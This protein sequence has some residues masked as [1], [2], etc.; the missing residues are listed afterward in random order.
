MKI[1]YIDHSYHAQTRSTA[2][3]L[4]LLREVAEVDVYMDEGWL[5]R[6]TL[7][8]EPILACGYDL[9]VL[10]QIERHAKP[11]NDS[12]AR[13]I[14]VPMH[15]SCLPFKDVF[16]EQLTRIEILCFCR[17]LYEHL[18]ALGLRVKY[19]Q[20]FP[21]PAGFEFNTTP[22]RAG[23]FW[24][25]RPEFSWES[26]KTLLG[27]ARLSWINIH[28][29]QDP[30]VTAIPETDHARY[31][32]R[33]TDWSE[34]KVEYARALRDA[35]IFFAPRLQEGLGLAFL[36]AMAMGKAV[37]AADNPTM[38]E[39]ITHRVNGYL[40]D[41]ENAEPIDLACFREIGQAGRHFIERGNLRWKRSKRAIAE[42]I[43]TGVWPEPRPT[44]PPQ[45]R[46]AP[47]EPTVSVISLAHTD[48]AQQTRLSDEMQSHPVFEYIVAGAARG[49]NKRSADI[50][51]S[52]ADTAKG[53]WVLFLE[54]GAILL[55]EHALAEALQSAQTNGDFITC[56]YT[57]LSSAREAVHR[58]AEFDYAIE[59]LTTNRLDRLWFRR[60]PRLS[61]TLINRRVLR[62][63]RFSPRFRLAGDID[64]F[65][66]CRQ[67]GATFRH[68]DT[69]LSRLCAYD[70]DNALRRTRECR[71]IFLGKAA[72]RKSVKALCSS[73]DQA[74]C[75][76][77]LDA[78][79]SA[80]AWNLVLNLSLHPAVARYAIDRACKYL[81]FLGLR[82]ILLR[83]LLRLR[84][85]MHR[86][87]EV[88]LH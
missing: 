13:V 43:A 76:P 70:V 9:I 86:Q 17:A 10:F 49:A 8:L 66:R 58:V 19:A 2:F 29:A 45:S 47:S 32:L 67:A 68:G 5:G 4:E 39:Y 69:V 31:N 15:D 53:E 75:D 44:G 51:N 73:L 46:K 83:L 30:F 21:D 64:F 88:A 40:F 23:F 78:W 81:R 72:N 12:Q 37:V 41:P 24:N 20:F 48:V 59:R 27:D 61:A 1:A 38:N 28:R 85:R 3:F 63:G 71:E 7:D 65:L 74:Q 50:L 80:G 60:L 36:E 79:T 57:E 52:A 55:D 16:W 25:R 54:P 87:G 6:D 22:A 11:L 82:G 56:H 35:G 33:F 14:F 18:D 77:L 34:N 62:Q 42:W 26:V 84:R